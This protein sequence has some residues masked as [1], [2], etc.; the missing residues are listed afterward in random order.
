MHPAPVFIS[1]ASILGLRVLV[2]EAAVGILGL[3]IGAGVIGFV[4]RVKWQ[5]RQARK[6]IKARE[7]D[8]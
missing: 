1:V 7:A 5:A 2:G 6:Q 3:L 8:S 4:I